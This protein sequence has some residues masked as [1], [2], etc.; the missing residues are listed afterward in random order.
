MNTGIFRNFVLPKRRRLSRY[1]LAVIIV[2]TLIASYAIAWD[3]T[4]GNQRR[5]DRAVILMSQGHHE[6]SLVL[7]NKV[8]KRWPRAKLALT[9]KGLCELYLGRYEDALESYN[10]IIIID[11]S[12]LQGLWGKGMSYEKLGNIKEAIQCYRSIVA[13]NPEALRAKETLE[14]LSRL[15]SERSLPS[16]Q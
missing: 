9:G 6:E 2:L 1:S 11:P 4:K 16:S 7:Y 3:R 13:I 10:R 12:N 15:E 8:L 5:L 14:R